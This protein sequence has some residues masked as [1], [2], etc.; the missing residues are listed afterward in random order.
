MM[1]M[2][3]EYRGVNDTRLELKISGSYPAV[4]LGSG[5]PKLLA[6]VNNYAP[7]RWV[8]DEVVACRALGPES[9]PLPPLLDGCPAWAA[10]TA[11][12]A[13]PWCRRPASTLALSSTRPRRFWMC[14]AE[15]SLSLQLISLSPSPIP[16]LMLK[17]VANPTMDKSKASIGIIIRDGPSAQ[18]YKAIV[19]AFLANGTVSS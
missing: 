15:P 9:P 3:F 5:N 8:G 17:M 10:C 11:A 6:Q 18:R 2:H 14:A 16:P 19:E 1:A 7:M 12:T 4:I 13:P